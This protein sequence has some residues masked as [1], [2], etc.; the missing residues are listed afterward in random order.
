MADGAPNSCPLLESIAGTLE[1]VTR[2][3][4]RSNSHGLVVAPSTSRHFSHK[5][6]AFDVSWPLDSY[7]RSIR[8]SN[9][10]RPQIRSLTFTAVSVMVRGERSPIISISRRRSYDVPSKYGRISLSHLPIHQ[11]RLSCRPHDSTTLL[12]AAAD[13]IYRFL[14]S[15]CFSEVNVVKEAS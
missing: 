3:L 15:R 9:S 11:P 1:F 13:H 4:H 5:R 14:P 7:N 8:C 6:A 12:E 10:R 2:V